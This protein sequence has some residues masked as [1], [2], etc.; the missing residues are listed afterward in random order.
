[1]NRL[2]TGSRNKSR[3]LETSENGGK[4]LPQEKRKISIHNLKLH[5]K[6]L[7]REQNHPLM[8]RGKEIIKIRM[9][10]NK[11]GNKNNTYDQ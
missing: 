6:E 8:G 5:L 11:I 7:E 3:Y 10:V 2:K 4:K 1:M 9:E